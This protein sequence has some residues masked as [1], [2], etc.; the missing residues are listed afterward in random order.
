MARSRNI[1]PGVFTD[2]RL[3]E[4]PWAGRWLLIG[5]P[6]VADREGRL[7]DR[8]KK[9]KVELLPFDGAN[10]DRLLDGLAERGFIRRYQVAGRRYIEIVGFSQNQNPHIKEAPSTI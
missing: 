4:M 9:I 5:L 3:A 6:T 1:K 10:V 7:E 2:D 8:P